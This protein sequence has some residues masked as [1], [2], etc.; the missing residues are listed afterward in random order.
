MRTMT[1]FVVQRPGADTVASERIAVPLAG[2]QELLVRIKAVGVG[3]HDSYFLPN[4]ISFPFPIGIE[5]AGVVEEVGPAVIGYQVG[6]RIAFVSSMQRKGGVWAEYAVVRTDA[7]ILPIP[8]GMSFERAAAVPVAGNTAL[9]ALH[10]LSAIPTGGAIFMAGASGAVG[11]FAVQLAHRRGWEVAASASPRNHDYLLAL[12]AALAVDYQHPGWPEEVLR[13]R[14]EGVDGALAIQ[15]Q[16]TTD[17]LRVVK[18]GGT[19]VTVSG[20]QAAP[21]GG[22]HVTGIAY[23]VDVR[24]DAIALMDDIVSGAVKLIIEQVYPFADAPKAL[25][26]VQTRR[27]RGKVVLSLA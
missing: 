16:T 27:A 24:A 7:L 4:D 19:V 26:K 5:A 22:V 1:A 3:I 11:T 23:D 20:D 15:P 10:P 2:P 12:G 13:W 8:D 9:R 14:S 17:T 25:A 18:G 6:D 21:V